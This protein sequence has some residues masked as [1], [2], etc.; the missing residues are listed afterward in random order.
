VCLYEVHF[1]LFASFLTGCVALCLLDSK[2]IFDSWLRHYAISLNVAGSIPDE[3]IKY[4]K[5]PNASCR[6]M[7]LG[8]T[9]LLIEMNTRYL[10]GVQALPAHKANNITAICEQIF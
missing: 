5:S 1:F 2:L 4:F 7:A 9:Q 10:F 6:T 3:V 8:S